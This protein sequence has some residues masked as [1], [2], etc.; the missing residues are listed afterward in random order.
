MEIYGYVLGYKHIYPEYPWLSG[1]HLSHRLICDCD[2]ARDDEHHSRKY[3]CFSA[4]LHLGL[5]S[6]CRRTYAEAFPVLWSTNHFCFED[7]QVMSLTLFSLT[8]RQRSSIK[9]LRLDIN[10]FV[11][12]SEWEFDLIA[13]DLTSLHGLRN[14]QLFSHLYEMPSRSTAQLRYQPL[15]PVDT[16]LKPSAQ[17]FSSAV[18]ATRRGRVYPTYDPVKLLLSSET[19]TC[20]ARLLFV[21][22]ETTRSGERCAEQKAINDDGTESQSKGGK[23][24]AWI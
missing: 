23:D 24:E 6:T 10:D 4:P 20:L 3:A 18:I 5:L 13:A 15:D 16:V 9:T 1:K 14:I 19:E 22:V 12:R 11:D 17:G 21:L 2:G 8:P 7:S